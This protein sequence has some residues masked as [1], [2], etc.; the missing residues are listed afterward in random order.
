MSYFILHIKYH[1]EDV[2]QYPLTKIL[3]YAFMNIK[4]GIHRTD[5]W[6]PVAEYLTITVIG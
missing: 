5:E 6:E 3:T 2:S 4:G 1:T